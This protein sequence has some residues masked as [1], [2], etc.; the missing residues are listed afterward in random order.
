M[1]TFK[2]GGGAE[3]PYNQQNAK[4]LVTF[5]DQVDEN[6]FEIVGVID[7]SVGARNKIN[8]LYNID[9]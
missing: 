5:R 4:L 9:A 1:V 6:L 3:G 2:E 7:D 8:T